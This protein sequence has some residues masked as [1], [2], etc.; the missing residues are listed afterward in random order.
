MR[1]MSIDYKNLTSGLKIEK[2]K[3][4]KEKALMVGKSGV[5]K[6]RILYAID[7]ACQLA[8]GRL[9]ELG[10]SFEMTMTFCMLNQEKKRENYYWHVIADYVPQFNKKLEESNVIIQ[11]EILKKEEKILFMRN[12]DEIKILDYESVP[13][14][15]ENESLISQ[16][17]K[18]DQIKVVYRG[19]LN[20]YL[21][22]V[23]FDMSDTMD[24]KLYD[25][26]CEMFK[27]NKICP[28]GRNL[29]SYFS[30][31][32]RYGMIKEIE[33]DLYRDFSERILKIYQDIFPEVEEISYILDNEGKYGVAIRCQDKWINQKDISSGML[34]TLWN[35]MNIK[36]LP[37]GAV[38]LL[39]ELENGLGVN[40]IEEVCDLILNERNDIQIIAT[41]HHPY[42]INN[43]SMENWMI[44]QRTGSV[45]TS[46]EASEFSLGKSKHDAYL[47][48]INKL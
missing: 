5:G 15:K 46:H 37:E 18:E 47:Q 13:K 22:D 39:D 1:I 34:K 26:I 8:T 14:P 11:E 30:P 33:P 31:F 2:V 43:I 35:I 10:Y 21:A 9:Q 38:L 23:E 40:C 29:S 19:F 6:T 32:E 45:I 4:I 41:S 16:Y 24:I 20:I 44:I 48:L 12:A 7:N 42:I 36:I 17:R 25:N 27:K 3:I 28:L